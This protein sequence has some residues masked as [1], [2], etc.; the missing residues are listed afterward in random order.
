MYG[1][2]KSKK[3]INLLS[4]RLTLQEM[5]SHSFEVY[6][7]VQYLLGNELNPEDWGWIALYL[8]PIL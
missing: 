7:Q 5:S 2:K 6:Y 8:S 3:A 4:L 1:I